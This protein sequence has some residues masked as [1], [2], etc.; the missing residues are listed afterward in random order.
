MSL[1]KP[2]TEVEKIHHLKDS[3]G[4]AEFRGRQG[5]TEVEKIQHLKQKYQDSK[6]L[7]TVYSRSGEEGR[8]T[9][10]LIYGTDNK[11]KAISYV[12]QKE[13]EGL[14]LIAYCARPQEKSSRC[15][16]VSGLKNSLNMRS[17]PGQDSLTSKVPADKVPAGV[18]GHVNGL[19]S[20][21]GAGAGG[22]VAP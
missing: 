22:S 6:R 7:Y 1:S 14:F 3:A 21:H 2:L 12:R 8:Y 10:S 19:G 11:H 13:L 16:Y 4:K 17:T 15:V 20:H 18:S 9:F 5:M